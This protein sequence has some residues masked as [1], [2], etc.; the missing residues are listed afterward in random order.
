M[1]TSGT[2]VW[3]LDIIDIAEEAFERAGLEMR[4]GYD[5]RTARRSLNILS[6]E[7]ANRGL[8][9][10]TVTEGTTALTP[11][12]ATY[13][14]P[15]DTIDLID[16]AVR[17]TI[18]GQSTD[19]RIDRIGVGTFAGIN[20]KSMTGRPNQVY[21][22]RLNAP[23]FTLWPVPDADYTLV[24]WRLRRIEDSATGTN[25]MDFPVRFL[26]AMI[27]GLAYHVAL[28]RPEAAPRLEL[29]KRDYEEQFAL[30][31]LEDR[32]RESFFMAPFIR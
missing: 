4:T 16:Q 8:N 10:W 13:A 12:V 19:Y 11:G 32:G 1:S 6:A 15:S 31:A 22:Q 25:M 24:H 29:L 5:M 27:A 21:V 17:V 23:N 18:N 7:W 20:N 30:A 28:K 14:L 2:A 9:L 26:P 3:N